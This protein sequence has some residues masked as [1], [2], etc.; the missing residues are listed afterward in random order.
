[1]LKTSAVR[2]CAL[3][4]TTAA[5][6]ILG[7]MGSHAA[8]SPSPTPTPTPGAT[9]S[10][11]PDHLPDPPESPAAT[12]DAT[13]DDADYETRTECWTWV[14]VFP[15]VSQYVNICETPGED[16]DGEDDGSDD[17]E[18]EW[19]G[20]SCDLGHDPYNE[21]CWDEKACY[22]D[23]PSPL[24]EEDWPDK[25]RPSET[26]IFTSF[27]CI[28]PPDGEPLHEFGWIDPYR[29]SLPDQGWA[30][31]GKLE[32]PAF[33]LGFEPA[34]LA[35]VGADTTFEV[36]GI[37]DGEIVGTEAGSLQAVGSFRHV[38]LKPGDDAEVLECDNEPGTDDCVHVYLETSHDE[39]AA[40][41][42]GRGSYTAQARLVYD[43]TYL[44]GGEPVSLP[45]V[46]DTLESPWNGTVVPVGEIQVLVQ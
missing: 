18:G 3:V 43:V 6:T 39:P 2:R 25:G 7:T 35:Y 4:V 23:I 17:G 10:A 16:D 1:M 20:P 44:M 24:A 15:G 32:T 11:D 30:A 21:F 37:G 34:G 33:T 38:E 13:P 8:E 41:L 46:P 36:D 31:L 19:E 9:Q 12:L 26:A 45:G 5:L 40:D 42:D 22:A 27:A 14:E 29:Y 28:V